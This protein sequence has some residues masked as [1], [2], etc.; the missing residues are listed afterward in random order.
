MQLADGTSRS[1]GGTILFA[2]DEAWVFCGLH[3]KDTTH[4]YTVLGLA[5]VEQTL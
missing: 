4:T 1:E 5:Q 2:E 3:F